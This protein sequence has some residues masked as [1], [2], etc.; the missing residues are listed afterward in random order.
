MSFLTNPYMVVAGGGGLEGLI[1]AG[2]NPSAE[3]EDKTE[4]YDGTTWTD[5]NDLPYTL[6]GCGGNGN[7]SD[8]LLVNGSSYP[9]NDCGT[10]AGYGM[11]DNALTWNGTS[12][13][14]ENTTAIATRE[15]A[16]GGNSTGG[17]R[18]TGN[19]CG[20]GANNYLDSCEEYNGTSWS[21]AGTYPETIRA[22]K[23]GGIGDSAG[24]CFVGNM[25][26]SPWVSA[27]CCSYDGTSWNTENSVPYS[28]RSASGD[29][30]PDASEA[31]EFGGY[32]DVTLDRDQA[33]TYIS[34]SWTD[35][36]PLPADRGGAVSL[37]VSTTE[38]YVWG[39][40][41]PSGVSYTDGLLW[42]DA[43]FSTA[44]GDLNNN[45][46]NGIGGINA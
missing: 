4:S 43:T 18:V 35:R 46:L 16:C 24:L 13:V 31:C 14:A 19:S 12:W 33:G 17:L 34:G 9:N 42:D 1:W 22:C 25:S 3:H 29:A 44:T 30:L 2:G 38:M 15:S 6:N 23:G 11:T 40:N 39:G 28:C 37:Y 7:S 45:H 36:S 32:S 21:T 8:A 20:G 41:A 26:S 27:Q 10:G 5:E